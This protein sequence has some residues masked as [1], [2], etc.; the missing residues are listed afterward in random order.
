METGNWSLAEEGLYMEA[1]P[2]LHGKSNPQPQGSKSHIAFG[3]QSP[4][5]QGVV[6]EAIIRSLASVPA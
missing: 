5:V 1:H 2:E 4:E 3:L 6:D